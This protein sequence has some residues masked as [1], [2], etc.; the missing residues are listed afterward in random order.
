MDLVYL[1]RVILKRKWILIGSAILAATIA[2]YLTRNEPKGYHSSSRISTGFAV[3]DEIRV[4]DNNYTL[5]DAEIKFNNAITTWT[6]ASVISLLS[7]ELILHDL[8]SPAPFRRLNQAQAES[9]VYKKVNKD[10]AIKVFEDKLETMNVLTSYKPEEKKLLEFLDLYGYSYKKLI[11]GI[12]ISQVARTDY[13]QVECLSENPEL[14]AFIVNNAFQ[15]FIRYYRGIRITKSQE[16]VDTLQSIME[17]KKQE[18]DEK[19]KLLRG[20]GI[21]DAV[22]ENTSQLDLIAELEKNLTVENNK[23]TD[24]YYELRKIN[25]KIAAL[26]TSTNSTTNSS[27]NEE[28]IIA[29]KAMNDAYSE[30]LKTNDMALLSKYNQLKAEYNTKYANSKPVTEKTSDNRNELIEKK[31]DLEVDI[32]AS[33]AKIKTVE[34]KISVLKANVSSVSSKGANVE[35]LMEEVKLTEKEYLDAKQKYNNAFD[36]SSSSVNN[37][38]QLQI[39]QPAI[40]PEPSKRKIIVGMAGTVTFFSSLL[41]IVL[42]TYLDSSIKTPAVFSRIV[43]LKLI[44]M[45]NFMNFKH[46]DLK[47]IVRGHIKEENHIEKRRNNIFRE[48][49]RKLRFEIEKSGKKIFLFTSTQKGEGKTTLI[50]ALSYSMSLSNKKILIIDT[51]FCNNDLTVQ[52]NGNPV[53][54][55]ISIDESRETLVSQVKTLSKDIGVGGIFIIGSEGGD[56]TPS[57]ILPQKNL[58]QQ[59]HSL[60]QEFDYIFLE[61]PPLNDF[62]DSKELIQYVDGVI[63]IFSATHIIKQIDKESLGFYKD[64]NGKFTGSVLNKVDLKNV[65]VI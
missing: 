40:E 43:N 56:Y 51:N 8:K 53:L 7:Y 20:E 35:S 5:F 23:Q 58:L 9:P 1:F 14:S 11:Q 34:Q 38:R 41:I 52:L 48:S 42:L 39:A 29:R 65:N 61:G 55:K 33:N 59:L 22:T 44:S 26:G 30:Y 6:S 24:D 62:T 46:K 36:M 16:S 57:E 18:L 10:E 21:V 27:N 12:T 45:V 37:F 64:L 4:N 47:D 50:Q 31:N 60:T 3:P 49:L 19:N 17:K 63:A 13:I 2:W 25:Q 28:L 54:E 15:Q 32:Q